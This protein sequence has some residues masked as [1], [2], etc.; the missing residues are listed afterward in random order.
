M[1]GQRCPRCRKGPLF[2]TLIK[3]HEQCPVCGLVHERDP[4]YFIGAMYFSYGL[5]V[6]ILVP[7]FF[8]LQWLL[9]NWPILVVPAVAMLL[10]LPFVPIVYRYSRTLWIYFDRSAEPG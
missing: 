9:P 1:L 5:G 4:G 2:K 8:F 6:L 10:Y 7:L 3:M